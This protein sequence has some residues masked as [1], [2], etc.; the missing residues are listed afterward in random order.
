MFLWATSCL[1]ECVVNIHG[2][3]VTIFTTDFA[4]LQPSETRLAQSTWKGMANFTTQY[5]AWINLQSLEIHQLSESAIPCL[6][7]IPRLLFPR[8]LAS[9]WFVGIYL[10]KLVPAD[11][12]KDGLGQLTGL[13]VFIVLSRLETE[14]PAS[15]FAGRMRVKA[16]ASSL[17]SLCASMSIDDASGYGSEI[18]D[19][20][21]LRLSCRLWDHPLPLRVPV[22]QLVLTSEPWDLT[23]MFQPI[24]SR[25]YS[26]PSGRTPGCSVF[27][28]SHR[29]SD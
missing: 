24:S 14:E 16:F 22:I 27:I 15:E 18:P 1:Q 25:S 21:A 17:Q 13:F 19:A 28:L 10:E 11:L 23:S 8:C 12:S 7:V 5:T 6:G 9:F 4:P 20:F 29:V 26:L 3:H 2:K